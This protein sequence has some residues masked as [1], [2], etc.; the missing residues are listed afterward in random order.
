MKK[1]M[2]SF[3]RVTIWS[4]VFFCLVSVSHGLWAGVVSRA[5]VD[6]A[7]AKS[8]MQQIIKD[9]DIICT[10]T[11]RE[12]ASIQQTILQ[13]GD[14]K[15]DG[16]WIQREIDVENI[17]QG[18]VRQGPIS[19]LSFMSAD[20]R[21]AIKGHLPKAG[22]CLLFLKSY[23]DDGVAGLHVLHS[24]VLPDAVSRF[25]EEQNAQ[26]QTIE[27]RLASLMIEC[28]RKGDRKSAEECLTMFDLL[29]DDK[30]KFSK[31]RELSKDKDLPSRGVVLAHR[32]AM[33]DDK[34]ADEILEYVRD[35]SE[36]EAEVFVP[37]I[38][39]LAD[40]RHLSFLA[41]LLNHAQGSLRKSVQLSL[42]TIKTDAAVPHL[43]A[44]LD[45]DDSLVRLRSL[46]SLSRCVGSRQKAGKV[47]TFSRE[48]D[49][50]AVKLWKEWWQNEGR[51]KHGI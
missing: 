4:I 32:L 31:L 29:A 20:R 37:Y 14:Q 3:R 15:I 30:S 41:G 22:R 43:I 33:K 49:A 23:K 50:E 39:N 1:H 51:K 17:V 44:L 27:S 38:E 10:G 11:I 19:V 28:A 5:R 8:F 45:S 35:S 16:W 34:V 18:H 25:V 48:N 24:V 36:A 2:Y 42:S 21:Y 12:S 47:V 26:T 13:E 6:K 46:M 7:D 9:A 40:S